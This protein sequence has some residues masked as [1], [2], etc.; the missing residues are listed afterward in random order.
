MF[1]LHLLAKR[2]KAGIIHILRSHV[3]P[4]CDEEG[5]QRKRYLVN[6]ILLAAS[7]LGRPIALGI[8]LEGALCLAIVHCLRGR[9]C[10]VM[11]NVCTFYM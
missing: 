3:P 2:F 4:V 11:F 8:L 9:V 5:R 10:D 1:H 7:S 6:S